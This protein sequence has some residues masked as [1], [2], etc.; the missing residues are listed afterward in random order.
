MANQPSSQRCHIAENIQ[1]GFEYEPPS[2][3]TGLSPDFIPPC[4]LNS[5]A[6]HLTM[7]AE[8]YGHCSSVLAEVLAQI[9]YPEWAWRV[10]PGSCGRQGDEGD[11]VVFGHPPQG[12]VW[13]QAGPRLATRGPPT[14]VVLCESLAKTSFRGC[15]L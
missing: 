13:C 5:V 9:P 12:H 15:R 2:L 1:F 7:Q 4:W 14:D 3:G 6:E 11:T 8:G 10:V